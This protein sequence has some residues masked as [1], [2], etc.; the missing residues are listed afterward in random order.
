MTTL[1]KGRAL[2]VLLLAVVIAGCGDPAP[3]AASPAPVPGSP[4]A[5]PDPSAAPSPVPSG[6]PE[7]DALIRGIATAEASLDRY[8]F[9]LRVGRDSNATTVTVTVINRPV[10]A[11]R[12]EPDTMPTIGLLAIGDRAWKPN[13]DGTWSPASDLDLYPYGA[14]TPGDLPAAGADLLT[15]GL[16]GRN[17]PPTGSFELVAA[18][19]L[20]DGV[21]TTHLRSAAGRS[22]STS[23]PGT[24]DLWLAT[25]GGYIVRYTLVGSQ[26]DNDV[27]VRRVN[28]PTLVLAEPT[29][30][31]P[32]SPGPS[33]PSLAPGASGAPLTSGAPST[34]APSVAP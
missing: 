23:I 10:P 15:S 16:I 34:S 8:V 1:A 29:N 31:V 33:T 30:V 22:A 13:D 28:D 4:S 17:G 19:E 5:S 21:A 20:V 26:V 14:R 9:A 7:V 2:G 6:G 32:A 18:N 24:L 3:S 11:V 27:S 25:Q 12:F